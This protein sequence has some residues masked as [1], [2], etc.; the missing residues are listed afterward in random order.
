M[1]YLRLLFATSWSACSSYQEAQTEKRRLASYVHHPC[2]HQAGVQMFQPE[3]V[4][5]FG[6]YVTHN[7]TNIP[8]ECYQFL[9]E[10]T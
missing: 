2:E 5:W 7:P 4:W 9:G 1:R 3:I 10:S 8:C 6:W